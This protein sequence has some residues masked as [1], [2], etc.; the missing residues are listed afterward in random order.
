MIDI[1]LDSFIFNNAKI[2]I[3]KIPLYV[4]DIILKAISITDCFVEDIQNASK[5]NTIEIITTI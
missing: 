5:V 1:T 3:P 4:I 2:K